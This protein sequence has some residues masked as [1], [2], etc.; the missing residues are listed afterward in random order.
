MQI[1]I[2]NNEFTRKLSGSRIKKRQLHKIQ[3]I[4][5]KAI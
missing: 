3:L 2:S 5:L 1:S 4:N